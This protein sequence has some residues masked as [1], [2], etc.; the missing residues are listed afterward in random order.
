LRSILAEKLAA[1]TDPIGDGT[2][3]VLPGGAIWATAEE[4]GAYTVRFPHER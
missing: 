3:F 4:S 1:A 2:R